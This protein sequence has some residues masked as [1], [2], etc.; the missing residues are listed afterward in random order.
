MTEIALTDI[1][2][3]VDRFV[4]V[5][6]EADAAERRAAVEALW[7]P[8]AVEYTEQNEYRGHDGLEKRVL[9]NYENLVAGQ[10]YRFHL[11][12]PVRAHHDLVVFRSTMTPAAGGDVEWTGLMVLRLGEDGRIR[13]DHQF[14]L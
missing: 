7:A 12:G 3:F 10:G 9:A 13:E 11:D 8:D 1:P 5:W 14:A 6:N 2:G 4:A